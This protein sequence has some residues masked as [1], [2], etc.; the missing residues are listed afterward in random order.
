MGYVHF[1]IEAFQVAKKANSPCGDVFVVERTPAHTIVIL[2]DGIGSGIK[3]NIA[4]TM[5]VA[6]LKELINCGFSIRAAFT[7][8]VKTMNKAAKENLPYCVF[9]VAQIMNDGV[10]SILTYDMP[11]PLF[12]SKKFSTELTQRTFTVD[13]SVICESTCYLNVGDGIMLMT[14]GVTQ[15]GL[16]RGLKFGW[17]TEGVNKHING[18]LFEGIALADLPRAIYQKVFD[19]CRYSND[20]DVSAVIAFSRPGICSNILTGPPSNKQ[21]DFELVRHFMNMAGHKIICGGTTANIVSK[22]LK[23]QIEVDRTFENHFTPPKYSIEGID[24]VTEGAVTLNQLYNIIDE[25]RKDMDD[26]NPVTELYDLIMMSDRINFFIGKSINPA[27]NDIQFIQQG[28]LGRQKIIPILADKLRKM[29]K[30]VVEE[31]I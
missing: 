14:D 19:L 25:D 18:L 23:K 30:L 22:H 8:L 13:N 1:E 7:S 24:L 20:D 10:T 6:R 3:A 27:S 4:A 17:G 11:K 15:A 28:L 16:G 29:G 21:K 26:F 12:I 2:A 5:C 9:A 31:E